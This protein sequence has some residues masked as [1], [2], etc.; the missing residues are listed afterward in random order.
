M[1][2]YACPKFD[3]ACPDSPQHWCQ[4][5]PKHTDSDLAQSLRA[6]LSDKDARI[7]ILE[8]VLKDCS[9]DLASWVSCA[10][11]DETLIYPTNQ[12]RLTRD[13]EPVIRARAILDAGEK[14]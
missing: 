5:C 13:M 2:V 6:Q 9:D 1:S 7:K 8:E 14:S 12:S 10:Y 4:E 11:P 3:E